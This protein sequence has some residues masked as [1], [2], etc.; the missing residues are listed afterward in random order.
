[1]AFIEKEPT[2]SGVMAAHAGAEPSIAHV[3]R[4]LKKSKR[5]QYYK[6][7]DRYNGTFCGAEGT[8]DD[9]DHKTN[10]EPFKGIPVCAECLRI[11]DEEK[12]HASRAN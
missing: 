1:V 4:P 3:R 9:H 6:D 7:L 10:G 8:W 12:R 2:N 11:R 5:N